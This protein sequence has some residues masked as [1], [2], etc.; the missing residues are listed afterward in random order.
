MPS[1]LATLGLLYRVF[2]AAVCAGHY[3]RHTDEVPELLHES[4]ELRLD[5]NLAAVLARQ[6]FLLEVL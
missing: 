4:D 6:L 5:T 3:Q 1:Y 2:F